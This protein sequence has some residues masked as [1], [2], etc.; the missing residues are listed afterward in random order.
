MVDLTSL[1]W[2]SV[3]ES[4]GM[5]SHMQMPVA[6]IV[7]LI[8]VFFLGALLATK[9]SIR[10]GLPAILGVLLLGIMVN[11]PLFDS[12]LSETMVEV[13]HASSLSLLLFY[14][15]LSTNFFS[16][17][18]LV[19]F[20]VFL[21]AGGVI[22]SSCLL[23][24]LIWLVAVGV[25]HA[26][27][28]L[29]SL[30]ISACFL[31]AACLA[32]TDAGATISMLKNVEKFVP[33]RV[34]SVLQFESSL[35]DPAAILFLTLA[36]GIF[37]ALNNS[38]ADR[39][40]PVAME[41]QVFL[42]NVGSGI[43]CGLILSY[44]S[45]YILKSVL[46]SRDQVLVLGL[47]IAMAS[48]GFTTLIG[49]SGY[50]ACFVTG[51]FLSNNIYD[52]PH[53]THELL[54]DSLES[55][56]SMMEL[57]IFLLFGLLFDPSNVLTYAVPGVCVALGLMIVVRPLSVLAFRR[58]SPLSNQN[59][60]LICWCGLRGAVPLALTY[61]LVRELPS[62]TG[63]AGVELLNLQD[64]I[65]T[66]VFIVVIVNLCFQGFTLPRFCRWLG[67]QSVPTN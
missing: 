19:L 63:L 24:L 13:L 16:L 17:R 9:L 65:Q 45:Q 35:N 59:V 28:S 47:S 21:A 31:M 62:V 4:V 51:L 49:G 54:E 44:L 6:G 7:A 27:P 67:S 3:T 50:V 1:N 56:S 42:R 36:A 37:T 46:T 25:Q 8:A 10:L 11:I 48:F 33:K 52:N 60:A 38:D 23:A 57:I 34:R 58:L 55:F 39:L 15:G 12:L 14:S 41:I 26:M 30:P 2:L 43:L 32:S 64:Y 29:P 66:L 53:I 40:V 20:G 5:E 18:G 61:E 22:L